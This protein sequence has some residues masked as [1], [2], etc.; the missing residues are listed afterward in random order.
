M[1]R[2]STTAKQCLLL[3]L[4]LLGSVAAHAQSAPPNPNASRAAQF[5]EVFERVVG[6]YSMDA[7]GAD[8]DADL[9]RLR[10]LLPP[11]DKARDIQ[12]RSVYCGSNRLT[13]MGKALAYSTDTMHRA[14]AAKDLASEARALFCRA[15]YVQLISGTQQAIAEIDKLIALL[16]DS[17]E[18][19]LLAEALTQRG[20]MLSELG[21]Q[22]KAMIDFQRARAGFREA[23]ITREVDALTLRMAVAYRRMGDW[24]QAATYF[25]SAVQRMQDKGNWERAI[26]NQ[27]QLGYLYD[28]SGAKQQSLAT[29]AQA[30]AMAK[31]HGSAGSKASAYIGLA[32]AQIAQGQNDQA[33]NTLEQANTEWISANGNAD[34]PMQLL[35]K[36]EALAGKGQHQS[37]LA[38]YQQA[39]PQIEKDGN[40]RYLAMV[41]RA[42]SSSQEALGQTAAALADYKRYTELQLALQSKMRLEQSRLLEYEY[43]IRRRD[44][45]NQT[46]RNEATAR[47]QQVTSLQRER[48]WQILALTLGVLLLLALAGLIWRQL[49]S[50][51]QLR[52]LATTDPLTGLMS[53]RAIDTSMVRLLE[54]A[55]QRK[56]PLSVL[57][58]DLD[59]FKRINDQYGHAAGDDVLKMV[60]DTWKL[61]LR[62]HDLLGRIGGEEFIAI[63]PNSDLHHAAMIAARLLEAT[64]RLDFS[65]STP[66]LHVTVSIGGAQLQPE[67]APDALLARADAALYR[68]KENGR[69]RFER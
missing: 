29:F 51:R 50:A 7:N 68:A 52:V 31:Q 40:Q 63:C 67:E 1:A 13:D 15:I 12:F 25:K 57:I 35:L 3:A 53:R 21:E 64:R 41:L 18:R 44:F 55:K 62:D 43:E 17:N 9:E 42:K 45:E 47:D 49:R 4:F 26:T 37:A 36:G 46:L 10:A 22:A 48:R 24:A 69:D 19:Q 30:V 6:P 60:T 39:E 58:L 14:H 23:G 27:I 8:Y 34:N 16:Q 5:D 11:G 20:A 32:T 54:R 61:Q 2:F 66:G 28:E 59:Y 33:L 38:L 56:Q 65:N